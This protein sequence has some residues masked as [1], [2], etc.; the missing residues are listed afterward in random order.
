MVSRILGFG[1]VYCLFEMWLLFLLISCIVVF[2][3]SRLVCSICLFFLLNLM[4]IVCF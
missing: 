1:R 2:C 3:G 4:R